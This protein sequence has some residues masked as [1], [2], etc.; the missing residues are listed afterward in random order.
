[1]SAWR[2]S[3]SRS[4]PTSEPPPDSAAI[5]PL[6]VLRL[7]RSAGTAILAQLALHGQLA[8][9][10][11]AEEKNRLLKMLVVAVLGFAGLL[12]VMLLLAALVLAL[13]WDTQYRVPA[14]MALI[15]VFGLGTGIAWH[16]FQALSAQSS[17]SFA[18]TRE[19][20]AAD[21]ALLKSKL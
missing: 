21:L 14:V 12:C 11:W 4:E 9:V 6:D 19:E 18:A 16:R 15:A 20:L 10:E 1:M 13:S 5:N 17:Q 2:T 7:L 3:E 8:R